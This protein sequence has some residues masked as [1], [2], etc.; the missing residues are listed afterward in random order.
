MPEG[1]LEEVMLSLRPVG[2]NQLGCGGA[3]EAPEG[4]NSPCRSAEAKEISRSVAGGM[5]VEGARLRASGAL[6]GP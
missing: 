1:F 3:G 2:K 6:A 4:R 5:R